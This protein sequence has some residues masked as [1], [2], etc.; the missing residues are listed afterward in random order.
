MERIKICCINYPNRDI[1]ISVSPDTT[2]LDIKNIYFQHENSHPE[3]KYQSYFYNGQL[4]N[5]SFTIDH[6]L[7]NYSHVSP[8]QIIFHII[9]EE[10]NEVSTIKI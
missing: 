2:I 3:P 5:D 9:I 1:D 6:I 10:V 7:S 8:Y 4:M